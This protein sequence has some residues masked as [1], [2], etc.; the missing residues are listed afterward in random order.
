[1][2]LRTQSHQ[3]K[4]DKRKAKVLKAVVRHYIRTASPVSSQAVVDHYDIS[5]SPATVRNDFA[6]LE[7]MGLIYQ[8]HPSAGRIPSDKGYRVYVDRLMDRTR[9]SP[10]QVRRIKS[11]FQR[12]GREPTSLVRAACKALSQVTGYPSLAAYPLVES[13]S[14]RH[15]SLHPV[16]SH[17]LLAVM[18]TRGGRLVHR[19]LP[20]PSALSQ[21]EVPRLSNLLNHH[22]RNRSL[23]ELNEIS[24]DDLSV[25]GDAFALVS[26]VLGWVKEGLKVSPASHFFVEGLSLIL[27]QPEFRSSAKA[28]PVLSALEE[29]EALCKTLFYKSSPE[30]MAISIGR[31]NEVEDLWECSLVWTRYRVRKTEGILG[32]VGPTRMTYSKVVACVDYVASLLVQSLAEAL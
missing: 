18:L 19:L 1:M 22:L 9:L 20:F 11:M 21:D 13:D 3:V 27:A 31:E 2:R 12:A 23:D 10:R 15:L 5:A 6:D 24:V 4:L 30:E 26:D 8:P 7:R 32:V 16:N 29:G 28:W 17:R 14:L 25:C